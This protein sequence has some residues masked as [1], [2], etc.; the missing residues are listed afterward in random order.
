MAGPASGQFFTMPQATDSFP[1][2]TRLYSTPSS[3]FPRHPKRHAHLQ[4][5]AVPAHPD[6][7]VATY[8][9]P[10]APGS[11]RAVLP[12]VVANSIERH[13][14]PT[15]SMHR[16]GQAFSTMREICKSKSTGASKRPSS[17]MDFASKQSMR[18]ANKAPAA[19]R[20]DSAMLFRVQCVSHDI[21]R[22]FIDCR[23][24]RADYQYRRHLQQLPVKTQRRRPRNGTTSI[25]PSP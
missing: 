22:A 5:E 2:D 3:P 15:T 19:C 21:Y 14:A 24:H 16:I 7:A 9:P 4:Q 17:R 18:H 1:L 25:C 23:R 13:D 6:F 8:P 10:Y 12:L 11:P 20:Q